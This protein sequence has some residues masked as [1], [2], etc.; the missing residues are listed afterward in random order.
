M[1]PHK[2]SDIKRIQFEISNYCN[3]ACPSCARESRKKN[4]LAVNDKTLSFNIIKERFIP[5]ELPNL[6][7]ISFCGNI[8]E[9]TIHPELEEILIYFCEN[10]PD[11]YVSIS[12]NGSTRN[13]SFWKRLAKISVKY[14]NYIT[15][16]AIDGLEDTN[17]IYRIGSS[18]KKI[19]NNLKAYFSIQ[20][21]K[22]DWQ[23]VVFDHNEHQIEDVK[24]RAKEYGFKNV[25]LRYSGRKNRDKVTVFTKGMIKESTEVVC[26]AQH[27]VQTLAPSMY[28]SYTGNVTPCCY[29][30][31]NHSHVNKQI[32]NTIKENKFKSN[33]H[34][35]TLRDIVEGALFEFFDSILNTD[36]TCF[37]HCK[38]N[39]VDHSERLK[40]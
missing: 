9:P 37:E 22:A 24:I 10:W 21:A 5:A 16:F 4:G 1:W 6:K 27:K 3:L 18:W 17:H 8:D 20:G 23:F 2:V 32:G 28:V 13:V 33:I 36:P 11:A 14:S 26:R 31:L 40:F 7:Q 29:Q 30:D 38:Q 19:E 34:S 15:M 12:T 25:S 35:S 39:R